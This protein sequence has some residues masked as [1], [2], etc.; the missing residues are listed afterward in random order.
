[1]IRTQIQLKEEQINALKEIANA[2]N[3]SLAEV[4]RRA[5]DRFIEKQDKPDREEL[6]RRYLSTAGCC[7]SKE[8]DVSINHDK[9]IVM[10][11]RDD[12]QED[13]S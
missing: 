1:M 12:I 11:I 7:S 10:S 4:V 2:E 8:G 3:I 9:Y 13:L 5:V 6:V